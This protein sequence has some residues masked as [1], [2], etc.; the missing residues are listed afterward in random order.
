MDKRITFRFYE[1]TKAQRHR[2]EFGDVLMQIGAV[3]LKD[4]EQ[5]LASDYYVRAEI[6]ESGRGSVFGEFTR[7]QRTNFPSEI[8]ED[9]RRP[10]STTN[11]LGHG[12]V[13]RYLPGTSQLGLQYDP[14]TISPSKIE[15]YVSQLIDGANFELTPIVR[16]D[17]WDK[18][19]EGDIRKVS[20]GI[21]QPSHLVAVERGGAQAISRSFKDMAE[22]Y[23]APKINI[24]L[25]MGHKKG[26]LAERIRSTVRHFRTQ[27]V[28]DQVDV[29][30]MKAKV[31]QE[32]GRTEDLD[33][34]EDILSVK[35]NLQL[36]D[37]DPETNYRI[38]LAALREKMHEWL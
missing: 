24:E 1:V 23:E 32:G 37:N 34:L 6:V 9:G 25:S 4:R 27:A 19:N 2:F 3:R 30:S 33:L 22:A 35:D 7:I 13:F 18:F 12:I 21:A 17:M 31:K 16:Q 36:K 15:A 28:R 8:R 11:P 20:I 10:L 26:A 38:K 5:H 14:R 29:T